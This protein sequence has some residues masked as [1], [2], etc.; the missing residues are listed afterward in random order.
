MKRMK[1]NFAVTRLR[2]PPQAWDRLKQNR[3]ALAGVGVVVVVALVAILAPWL[4]PYDP[5]AR[6][7]P[8][9]GWGPICWA[10]TCSPA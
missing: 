4:A 1:S 7:P 9:S 2:R 10:G 8:A 5:A 3:V 6:R